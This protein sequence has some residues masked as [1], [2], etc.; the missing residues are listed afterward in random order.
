MFFEA[1]ETKDA[2]QKQMVKEF[3]A[4]TLFSDAEI[5]RKSTELSDQVLFVAAKHP[6]FG[7]ITR[8]FKCVPDAV[9]PRPKK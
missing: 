6:E 4:I 7:E 3:L 2:C 1:F 5:T 8:S 9:D